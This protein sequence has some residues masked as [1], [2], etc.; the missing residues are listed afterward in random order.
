MTDNK[1]KPQV[2][3]KNIE[4][5]IKTAVVAIPILIALF[6]NKISILILIL[7]RIN[8]IKL[9]FSCPMRNIKISLKRFYPPYSLIIT[10]I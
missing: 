1:E 8:L 10:L 9:Q 2:E 6:A 4:S 7:G 5:R 3:V